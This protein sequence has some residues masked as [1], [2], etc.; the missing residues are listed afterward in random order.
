MSNEKLLPIKVVAK[1]TGLTAYVIRAWEKRY[2]AI[3]PSRSA[4]NRR[5]YNTEQVSRLLLL[6][7][8]IQNGFSIG[9]IAQLSSQ[10]ILAM[11]QLEKSDVKNESVS[12]EQ[13]SLV[14]KYLDDCLLAVAEIDSQKLD[15]L[16][17]KA[18]IELSHIVIIEELIIPLLHELGNLWQKGELRIVQEHV[19]SVVIRNFL[20]RL[21]S[22][23]HPS[24]IAPNLVVATPIGQI[25]ELGALIVAVLAAYEGWKP[26]YLGINLPAEEIAKAVESHQA[27]VVALSIIYPT[28]DPYLHLELKKLRNLLGKKVA[29][30]V[31]GQ[32]AIGYQ[33]TLNSTQAELIGD[34]KQ[35]RS[36]LLELRSVTRDLN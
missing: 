12:E 26:I 11:L 5:F 2:Q 34:L 33:Q 13:F 29:L 3:S 17:T 28:D 24:T 8:A 1:K 16:L 22:D 21:N 31:G 19:A 32:S 4:S 30:I 23:T 27:K 35:F 6:N 15:K 7:Q 9:Q 18:Q 36:K 20:G 10:E 25:H 14:K